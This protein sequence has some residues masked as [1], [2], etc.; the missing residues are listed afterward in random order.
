MIMEKVSGVQ[1]NKVTQQN[2]DFGL[3][4]G[5]GGLYVTVNVQT[6]STSTQIF[7]GYLLLPCK[8]ISFLVSVDKVRPSSCD[9]EGCTF[10]TVTRQ[11]TTTTRNRLVYFLFQ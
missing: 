3:K 8:L 5:W 11:A 6:T 2:L 10:C 4:E 1:S 7:L 9:R